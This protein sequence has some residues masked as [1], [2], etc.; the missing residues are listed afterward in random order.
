M[1]VRFL[2]NK[3]TSVINTANIY[4]AKLAVYS[5]LSPFL[6]WNWMYKGKH[7]KKTANE[8]GHRM[9]IWR[10]LTR[11]QLKNSLGWAK[12]ICVESS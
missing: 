1:K 6:N 12:K 10:A 7:N 11:H 4:R 5:L 9:P 3:K 8:A 2:H